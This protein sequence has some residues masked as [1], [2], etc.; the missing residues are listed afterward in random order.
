MKEGLLEYVQSLGSNGNGSFSL[1]KDFVIRTCER[2][3]TECSA[4]YAEMK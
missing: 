3:V 1:E 4:L 2:N